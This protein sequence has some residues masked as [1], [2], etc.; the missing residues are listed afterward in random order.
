MLDYVDGR[1]IIVF[2]VACYSEKFLIFNIW[3]SSFDYR[4]NIVRGGFLPFAIFDKSSISS[5][6][7]PWNGFPILICK[8]QLNPSVLRQPVIF[9]LIN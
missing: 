9:V 3:H 6:Y 2:L 4:E 7:L 1:Q 8:H 5:P